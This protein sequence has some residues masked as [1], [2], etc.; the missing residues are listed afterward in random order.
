MGV[1]NPIFDGM[2]EGHAIACGDLLGAGSD[3]I[4]AGWR[5]NRKNPDNFGIKLFIP[6]DEDGNDWESIDIDTDGMACEDLK[7]GDLNGDGRLDIVACGRSTKNLRIYF[8]EG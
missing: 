6:K 8:N 7:L 1:R 3:Q 4:V 5:G 2:I